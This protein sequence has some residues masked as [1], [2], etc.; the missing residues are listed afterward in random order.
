MARDKLTAELIERYKLG[1]T[2]I[3]RVLGIM[4]PYHGRRDKSNIARG[5]G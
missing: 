2:T 5:M 3:Y 4:L 1:K